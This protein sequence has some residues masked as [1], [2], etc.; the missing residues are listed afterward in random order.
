MKLSGVEPFVIACENPEQ[1]LILFSAVD[2]LQNVMN[3]MKNRNCRPI[4]TVT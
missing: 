2:M 4:Q 1:Q 3:A